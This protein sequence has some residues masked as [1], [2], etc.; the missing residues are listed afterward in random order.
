[1]L[2]ARV[3]SFTDK[4]FLDEIKP[5]VYDPSL[6]MVTPFVNSEYSILGVERT[7]KKSEPTGLFSEGVSYALSI[8]NN[9][10][11]GLHVDFH[12]KEILSVNIPNKDAMRFSEFLEKH[13][14]SK[15]APLISYLNKQNP[16]AKRN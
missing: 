1:M 10:I 7:I 16:Y 5:V 4:K 15:I 9:D 14:N 12:N 11:F 2:N 8:E 6:K 13:P 3:G